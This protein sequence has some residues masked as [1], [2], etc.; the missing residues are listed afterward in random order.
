MALLLD[1]YFVPDW[2]DRTDDAAT[3]APMADIPAEEVWRVRQDLRGHLFTFIRERMRFR[4]RVDGVAAPRV[5]AGGILL[6]PQALTVGFARRF[7]PYKRPDLIF[8]DPDRLAAILNAARHPVQLVFAG[9]AH[10]ADEGGKHA[11]QRVYRH[12]VDP[13]FAGRVAF[14]DD[15]DMHVGHFLVQ[16]C[17]VWLNNP[18]RP[19]EAS[20]TSGMKASINGVLNLSIGDGWWPEGYDGTNGWLIDPGVTL[21]DPAAQDAADAAALYRLLEDTIVPAFY[22]RDDAGLPGRWVGMVKRAVMTVGPRFSTA[23]MLKDYVEQ[24][25]LPALDEGPGW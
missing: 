16:G 7:T 2:R 14:V 13:R 15:Y 8:H 20:G 4:W 12:A 1:R 9:K 24:M 22:E 18:R 17:D 6:D 23:R 3:W 19:L 11:L 21:D 10:P 25:Y 5:V